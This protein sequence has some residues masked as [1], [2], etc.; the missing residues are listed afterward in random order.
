LATLPHDAGASWPFQTT[1]AEGP[2]TP[3]LHDSSLTLLTPAIN[4]DPNPSK[5]QAELALA[6]N[7][8][9]IDTSGP[10]GTL[11]ELSDIV[12]AVP[13]Q[14][15][16]VGGTIQNYTVKNGE[17]L[18]EI[19]QRFGVSVNTILWANDIKNAKLVKTG[20]SLIILPASGIQH[21]VVKG[22]TLSVLAQKYKADADDIAAYNGLEVGSVLVSGAEIII[23][24]GVPTATPVVKTK[25]EPVKKSESKT[26][27]NTKSDAKPSAV[28]V[29]IKE[30]GSVTQKNSSPAKS[31]SFGSPI[32][33]G[34]VTQGIH[35]WNGV[36][37]GAP[38][39]TPVYA[40]ADG[41]V[42]VSKMSGWNGGYGNSH[43][44]SG[45]VSVGDS[46]AKGD[47]LGGVGIS[48][49]ATGYHLHFE[50]RGARNPF[51]D[52]EELTRCGSR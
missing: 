27:A 49:A 28:Q 39:G 9:L 35:G 8:A 13:D 51:A 11:P 29:K 14:T 31:S 18:S 37:I 3:L 41:T 34:L 19:A 20:T 22:E 30:P 45:N 52:C 16:E 17:S 23:P 26:T 1:R 15:A 38:N 46:I 10:Q 47:Q 4:A 36:D 40:S 42:I 25:I 21:T 24:G 7:S 48:G 44:S 50:V 43:L 5:G 2:L 12:I 33:G 6:L 32:P